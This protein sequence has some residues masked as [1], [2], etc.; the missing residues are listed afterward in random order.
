MKG[1]HRDELVARD[2]DGALCAAKRCF[3][4]GVGEPGIGPGKLGLPE[5]GNEVSQGHIPRCAALAF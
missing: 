2:F 1:R 4:K 5:K 3:Q